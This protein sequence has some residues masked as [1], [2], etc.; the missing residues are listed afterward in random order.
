MSN[1]ER[2]RTAWGAARLAFAALAPEIFSELERPVTLRSVY[3]AFEDRLG[4]S[5]SRF[6]HWVREYRE[7]E[8]EHRQQ[9]SPPRNRAQAEPR[10]PWE[11]KHHEPKQYREGSSNKAFEFDPLDALR[12]KLI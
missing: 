1:K 2:K 3:A 4:M 10:A 7:R 11:P 9:S 6:C 12:K 5:Y 8:R